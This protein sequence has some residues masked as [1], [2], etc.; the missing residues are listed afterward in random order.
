M[1]VARE[2]MRAPNLTLS[3]LLLALFAAL[4]PSC[5]Q[6]T[7]AVKRGGSAG[8]AESNVIAGNA[9]NATSGIGG[10]TS[11]SS[12]AGMGNGGN[13]VV[14]IG[15][16]GNGGESGQNGGAAGNAAVAPPV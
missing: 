7:G 10:S 12:P 6:P 8:A 16:G 1:Y 4:V 14:I 5:L 3:P 9:G 11:S 15:D 13:G 2:R